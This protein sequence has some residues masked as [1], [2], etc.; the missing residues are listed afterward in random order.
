MNNP[1]SGVSS[2]EFLLFLKEKFPVIHNSNFF[3]RDLDYGV[4]SFLQA[5]G[6]KTNHADSERIAR[7]MADRLV[8]EGIFKKIDHQSWCLNYPRFALPRPE[9]ATPEKATIEKA[10][11]PPA[12]K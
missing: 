12:S 8:T 11:T 10:P 1:M 4:M 5:R 2:A 9:K 3:F 6:K 7:E